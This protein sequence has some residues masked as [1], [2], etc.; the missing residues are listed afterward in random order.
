MLLCDE[1]YSIAVKIDVLL[2]TVIQLQIKPE[3]TT[4]S[5]PPRR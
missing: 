5:C 4:D 1:D 2:D 3:C